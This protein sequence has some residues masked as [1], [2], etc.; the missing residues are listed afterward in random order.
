MTSRGSHHQHQPVDPM[1]FH[2]LIF[3]VGHHR[4]LVLYHPFFTINHH[5][6]PSVSIRFN[7][8]SIHHYSPV[9]PAINLQDH[10]DPLPSLLR[11]L[12][13][14][15]LD[16]VSCNLVAQGKKSWCAGEAKGE[17]AGTIPITVM[18]HHDYII[19]G[20]YWL[21]VLVNSS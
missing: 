7:H 14:G 5:H 19:V 15:F 3:I 2:K 21:I 9:A 6:Q 18:K 20:Y 1:H 16:Q 12:P 11:T 4:P 8:H 10:R 17:V 13:L